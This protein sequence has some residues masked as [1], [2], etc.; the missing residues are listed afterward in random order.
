M[1]SAEK[2]EKRQGGTEDG[3]VGGAGKLKKSEVGGIGK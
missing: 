1:S 2:G 3:W